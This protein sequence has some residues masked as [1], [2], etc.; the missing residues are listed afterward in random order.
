MCESAL[1][2][3]AV[4]PLNSRTTS[5][6]VANSVS[7]FGRILFTPVW[8]AAVFWEAAGTM[9]VGVSLCCQ[10]GPLP[11]PQP[12]QILWFICRHSNNAVISMSNAVREDTGRLVYRSPCRSLWVAIP[13]LAFES[14]SSCCPKRL[15]VAYCT[16]IIQTKLMLKNRRYPQKS[17][18][19]ATGV[20]TDVPLVVLG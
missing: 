10:N 5:K 8:N 14:N 7:N 17:M 19:S 20:P 13:T 11:H 12:L 4:S 2:T 9:R 3:C 6:D 15:S 1:K 18:F 16:H